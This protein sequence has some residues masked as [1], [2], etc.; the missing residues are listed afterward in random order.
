[1]AIRIVLRSLT[2]AACLIKK[3]GRSRRRRNGRSIR[4]GW[5]I[6]RRLLWGAHTLA[7]ARIRWLNSLTRSKWVISLRVLSSLIIQDS[8]LSLAIRCPRV[9]SKRTSRTRPALILTPTRTR[10]QTE[11]KPRIEKVVLFSRHLVASIIALQSTTCQHISRSKTVDRP[12]SRDTFCRKCRARSWKM[13]EIQI[14]LEIRKSAS[15]R[16]TRMQRL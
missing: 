9:V 16:S 6:G 1:M 3:S 14:R 11:T 15:W 7:K 5:T 4:R 10:S 8:A 12:V 13:R 2:V